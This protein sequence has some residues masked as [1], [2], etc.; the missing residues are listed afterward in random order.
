VGYYI[1]GDFGS[2]RVWALDPDTATATELFNLGSGLTT[3]G[4]DADGEILVGRGS[5]ISRISAEFTRSDNWLLY[6]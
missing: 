2:G 3:F 4:L 6:R 5:T 1:F